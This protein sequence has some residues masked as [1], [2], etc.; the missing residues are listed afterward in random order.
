MSLDK[1]LLFPYYFTLYCRNKLFDKGV[2][3]SIHYDIPSICVGNIAVGG[4]GKTPMVEY[5]IR[6][7]RENERIAVISRG[8]GR[9]TKGLLKVEVNDDYRNVGDEPLQIKRKFPDVDVIVSA[10]RRQAFEMLSAL[11]ESERPTLV[12]LDDAF[13]HRKVKPDFSILLTSYSRPYFSDNLMPIGRLRDLRSQA[14]RADMVVVTKVPDEI[15][16]LM[17]EEWRK[18]L[19]LKASVPLLFAKLHYNDLKPVFPDVCD[20]RYSYSKTGILFSGIADDS[21][22]K[23][24][25]IEK[26]TIKHSMKFNDHHNFSKSDLKM[27]VSQIKKYNTS[28]VMTTEKDAQRLLYL[29]DIPGI[30]KERLFYLPIE[31]EIIPYE[32]N[33]EYIPEELPVLGQKQMKECI[34]F[35]N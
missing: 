26:Y 10:S 25:I 6:M 27:L 18:K 8:Y 21:M 2:Y 34:K 23:R 3:K 29:K 16:P 14:Q 9:K 28:V 15:T 35:K 33:I 22:I 31:C 17:R 1:I 19:K 30:L 32:D 13:Q 4:T 24:D 11:P 12:I 20:Q 5:L 7:Y